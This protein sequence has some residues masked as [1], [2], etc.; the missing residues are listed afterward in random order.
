MT[1]L[2]GYRD[3]SA[4]IV[5]YLACE[6][7]AVNPTSLRLPF[8]GPDEYTGTPSHERFHPQHFPHLQYAVTSSTRSTGR[9][10]AGGRIVVQPEKSNAMKSTTTK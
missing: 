1:V 3:V 2:K 7:L 10:P 8:F 4:A 5:P 9:R 6:P